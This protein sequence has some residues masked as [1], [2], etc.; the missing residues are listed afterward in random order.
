MIN[1]SIISDSIKFYEDRGFK[2]IET[3]W[4]V[5]KEISDITN[6]KET[7]DFFISDKNKVLVASGEQ[8]FL[9][10]Y[11][12]GFLPKGMF[13][14]ITPCFRNDSFGPFHTKYFIKNELIKT[15]VVN[16]FELNN[17]IHIAKEFLS[18]YLTPITIKRTHHDSYDLCYKDIELGS[19]GI[20][21]CEFLTWIYGTGVAEPRF[22]RVVD[23]HPNTKKYSKI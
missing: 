5:T 8:S 15:D 23:L 12:K 11:N 10:L 13:Q 18:K 14:T 19:Y 9:Y 16:N 21:E 22:S 20:R 2:H 3:P 6:P 4:T 7:T 1:Y 17:I